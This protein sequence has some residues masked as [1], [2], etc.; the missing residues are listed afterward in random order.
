MAQ[1][2][3]GELAAAE[4]ALEKGEVNCAI[5]LRACYAMSGTDAVR[6]HQA[7]KKEL[8]QRVKEEGKRRTEVEVEVEVVKRMREELSRA[9]AEVREQLQVAPFARALSDARH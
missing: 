5:R 2:V 1:K 4:E 3:C 6:Y 8:Q 7:E 9:N